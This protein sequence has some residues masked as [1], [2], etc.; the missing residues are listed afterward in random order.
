M[1]NVHRPAHIIL[2]KLKLCMY[3]VYMLKRTQILLDAETK[4]DLELVSTKKGKS[5]SELVRDYVKEK[6]KDD[7]ALLVKKMSGKEA[8]LAIARNPGKGPGDSEYDKYA[9]G[10]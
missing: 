4:R 2:D 9:Y 3:V 7:K 5:V 10:F 8:L 1:S 6:V